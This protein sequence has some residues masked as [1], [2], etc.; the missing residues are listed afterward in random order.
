MLSDSVFVTIFFLNNEISTFSWFVH[1]MK[2]NIL[3]ESFDLFKNLYFD[4]LAI[5]LFPCRLERKTVFCGGGE[6]TMAL[7]WA[8]WQVFRS[9]LDSP[10]D[11]GVVVICNN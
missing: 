10:L 7:H 8:L 6:F 11:I 2:Y 3:L 9:R 5:L 1:Y 4:C